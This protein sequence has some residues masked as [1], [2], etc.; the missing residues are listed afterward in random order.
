MRVLLAQAVSPIVNTSPP[1][2]L[3]Y[4]G[5]VL[6]RAGHEVL[7]L[8]G[9]APYAEF[10]TE[11]MAD[12]I[13]AWKP[14]LV[15]LT[16]TVSFATHTYRLISQIRRRIEVPI[17]VGG[18]H[19]TIL[20]EEPLRFGADMV[21]RGEGEEGI[22]EV[23]GYLEGKKGAEEILG[24]SYIGPDGKP[25]HNP[26]RPL[27]KDLD[28]IP[29]PAK[30]LFIKEHYYRE[31]DDSARF[32]N[33]ITSRGC[34]FA[35]TYCCNLMYGRRWRAR[36]P[37]NVVDEIKTL[38]EEYGTGK[39]NWV[40]DAAT[41]NQ[42]R[43]MEICQL[44][45]D[46]KLDISWTCI[47]RLNAIS[48]DLLRMMKRAGCVGI[49]YGIESGNPETLKR[50]RKGITVEQA[51]RAVKLTH[52]IGIECSVNFMYG[53]PWEMPKDIRMTTEFIKKIS[54]YV[55]YIQPGGILTPLPA[56]Q[57]YEE[58]KDRYGFEGWWLKERDEKS[59]RTETDEPLF[60]RI[61]FDY[62]PL[63][64]NWFNYPPEVVR[65][66][67]RAATVVGR[68]NLLY[69]AGKLTSNRLLKRAIREMIYLLVLFSRLLYRFSPELSRRFSKPMIRFAERY[70]GK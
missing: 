56:T 13:A 6:E 25:V 32:G 29:F 33:I 4:L 45:I 27:I 57:I 30:H 67:E 70:H 35:C 23:I 40:D 7:I 68:H 63:E 61:F 54:P 59:I 41:I 69:H 53:F 1:L 47:T 11:S 2:G 38:M 50:I 12:E 10:T 22:L 21:L 15:G 62:Y 18:A 8:D 17:I 31:P 60:Q 14:D 3:G 9:G 65:E 64:Q 19:A 37:R 28:A 43:M 20:P 51:E 44:I 26:P 16:L 66:I 58:F 55:T 5:A 39:F 36:S 49:T 42:R 52:Q 34:P 24:L 46:E 48:E